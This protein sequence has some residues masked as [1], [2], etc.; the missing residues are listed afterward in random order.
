MTMRGKDLIRSTLGSCLAVYSSFY[1]RATD[2]VPIKHQRPRTRHQPLCL[3]SHRRAGLDWCTNWLI[4]PNNH[5]DFVWRQKHGLAC[6]VGGVYH[7]GCTTKLT[8]QFLLFPA[9]TNHITHFGPM[10]VAHLRRGRSFSFFCSLIA[11]GK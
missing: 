9:C 11:N 10:E 1:R 8:C 3:F 4:A 2:K 5:G 7:P 6:C